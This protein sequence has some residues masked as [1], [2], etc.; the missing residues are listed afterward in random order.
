MDSVKLPRMPGSF[1]F[2][3]DR[4]C[5]ARMLKRSLM[6]DTSGHNKEIP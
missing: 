5:Q 2:L 6:N 3:E 4:M 1:A